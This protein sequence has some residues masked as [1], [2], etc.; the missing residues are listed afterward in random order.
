MPVST[1]PPTMANPLAT[2]PRRLVICP[3]KIPPSADEV[4]GTSVSAVHPR[5]KPPRSEKS[6]TSLAP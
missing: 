5:K 4:T 3:T 2:P 1:S 6:E